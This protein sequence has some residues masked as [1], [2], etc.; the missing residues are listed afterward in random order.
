MARS[1]DPLSV[2]A[3]SANAAWETR[4]R[5]PRARARAN[6]C[7]FTRLSPFMDVSCPGAQAGS[8]VMKSTAPCGNSFSKKVVKPLVAGRRSLFADRCALAP[9]P[10]IGGS[11]VARVPGPRQTASLLLLPPHP[12]RGVFEDDALGQELVAN[13]VALGEVAGLAGG[14]SFGDER[15]DLAVEHLVPFRE[16]VEHGIDLLHGRPQ[17]LGVGGGDG[18]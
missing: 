1:V 17:P 16:D 6:Q 10:G 9:D 5:T 12:A 11:P 13:A 15:F 14:I 18:A 4:T 2:T 3:M 7:L 8:D